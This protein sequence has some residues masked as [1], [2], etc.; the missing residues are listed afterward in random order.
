MLKLFGDTDMDVTP[1][2]AKRYNAGLISMP[3][4]IGE[5]TI[6]PY[7][8]FEVF[9]S[10]EF[11]D[12]LRG[13][14][15]PTTCAV[16]PE[17]YREIFEAEFSAG[18]DILYVHFSAA[19]SSTFDFMT[20]VVDEL[21]QKYPER[22]FYALDT[23]GISIASLAVFEH[24]GEML[25]EGK[26]VEEILDWAK[27]GIYHWAT[28]YFA[29]DLNF[30]KRSGRVSGLA[31]SMGTLIGVRPIIFMDADGKM[32]TIGK[33]RGRVKAVD[34]VMKYVDELGDDVA[35]HRIY[36]AHCDAPES[37][38]MFKARLIERFGEDI[39][40]YIT[41]LNPTAGCHCGPSSIGVCFHA[42]HR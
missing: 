2:I 42:I 19:M 25:K 26:S 5:D 4:S 41:P 15:M 17:K 30:F 36:I 39:D 8:D 1:E 23:R 27:E 33:E 31:A 18:N 10:K 21:L 38:A 24:V 12:Q 3:Y 20:T 29:E 6:Y 22:R 32:K 28:Y 7:E 9:E 37:A 34:R 35:A 13:G 16:N 40:L 11:Y 14:L